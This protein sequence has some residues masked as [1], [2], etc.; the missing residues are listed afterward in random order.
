MKV[1]NRYTNSMSKAGSGCNGMKGIGNGGGGA[2]ILGGK[3][4]HAN[5]AM[6]SGISTKKIS[7]NCKLEESRSLSR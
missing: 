5:C 4:K 1:I 7:I 2:T 6:F 3:I